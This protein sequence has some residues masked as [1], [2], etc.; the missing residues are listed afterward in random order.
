MICILCTYSAQ[1]NQINIQHSFCLTIT[2][3]SIQLNIARGHIS[4]F[5]YPSCNS[6]IFLL[7][8]STHNGNCSWHDFWKHNLSNQWESKYC[9]IL[10]PVCLL[11]LFHIETYRF[12]CYIGMWS[13]NDYKLYI[14][15]N[16]K[17]WLEQKLFRSSC[18]TMYI[19]ISLNKTKFL[20]NIIVK[21]KVNYMRM[22]F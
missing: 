12:L 5:C 17:F 1:F 2:F 16:F 22:I 20:K 13:A 15:K 6:H 7:Y 8:F 18:Y 21:V 19:L 10:L 9:R 4:P 14:K 3:C 11:Q